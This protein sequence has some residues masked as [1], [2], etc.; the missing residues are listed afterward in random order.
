MNEAPPYTSKHEVVYPDNCVRRYLVPC[1]Y[2]HRLA[3]SCQCTHTDGHTS[4]RCPPCTVSYDW[5]QCLL[6]RQV[7]S[8]MAENGTMS[9]FSILHIQNSSM[10]TVKQYV[11]PTLS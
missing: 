3:L 1:Q 11:C 8:K 5:W 7:S 4:I 2:E 9:W 10:K 6:Q